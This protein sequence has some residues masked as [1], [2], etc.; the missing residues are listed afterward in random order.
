MKAL[1]IIGLD[2][3]LP[4]VLG[5]LAT[6]GFAPFGYYGLTMIAVIGLVAL[7][8][9]VSARRGALRGFVFG[10]AHFGTGIYWTFVSTYYYGGAPLPMAIGLVCLLTVYMACYPMLVGA[11]AGATRTLPRTLWA[12]L[13]VPGAWLLGELLRSWVLTGFPWLS[14]GYALIDAPVTALAPIGG[15]YFMGALM[16]VG[17]GAIVLLF[18]GALFA[19]AV[20]VL[21]I[22]L[23]PLGLWALPA[24][25]H[26]T[27]PSGEAISVDVVQGNFPQQ[28]KWDPNNFTTTLTRYRNLTERSEADLVVWPEVAIPAPADQVQRYLDF[29]DNLAGK[30]GQTVLAG[31]LVHP[32]EDKPYYN[33]VLALGTGHGRYYKR[34]LVPFGE[35][36]PVPDFVMHW[37][38]GINMRYSSF[39][40]GADD[41]PLISVDGVK[42][43]LSICFEDAFGYE[44]AKALPQA[45]ILVN[46]TNDA[47]FA[48][49]TAADQ[50][51]EIA[52]MRA[53]ESGRPMLRA[54]NTGISAIIDY[55]GRIRRRTEQ[56]SV[57][58]IDSHVQPRSGLTPY[59]RIGDWPLW[60][61]GFLLTGLGL[62]AAWLLR[63][64]AGR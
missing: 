55:D 39:G 60:L 2:L 13:F 10:L 24:A 56:F 29:I 17:A 44:I 28:V 31:V 61:A 50:H 37:L 40:F 18:V 30:R 15:V 43:G 22:A 34:H 33:A 58:N 23:A 1:R 57:A 41:Q 51:L 16:M 49:T 48:G 21:I 12:L 14:L 47:W 62:A 52:R 45:G 46:V 3:L 27:R 9:N 35:Y 38:D 25:A 53:L 64:R 8:W 11:F 59:M 7:W 63:R 4:A 32:G 36:F 19:R 42:L 5:G 26:W 54:A 20:A 6:L